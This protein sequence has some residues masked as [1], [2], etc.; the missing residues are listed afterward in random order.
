MK[1]IKVYGLF[2]LLM[3]MMPSQVFA[4]ALWKPGSVTPPRD[5]TDGLLKFGPCG[6]AS[7]QNLLPRSR[8]PKIFKP[9]EQVTV[10]WIETINHGGLFVIDY[11]DDVYAPL[12]NSV[13]VNIPDS[14]LDKIVSGNPLVRSKLITIPTTECPTCSIRIVQ[15]MWIKEFITPPL[16]PEKNPDGSRNYTKYF[17]CADI[18]IEATNNTPPGE[19][20]LPAA[21]SRTNNIDNVVLKWV[22]PSELVNTVTKLNNVAYRVLILMG[23]P[24]K[25]VTDAPQDGMQYTVAPAGMPPNKIGTATIVYDGNLETATILG[26]TNTNNLHFKFYTYN[27]SNLYSSTGVESSPVVVGPVAPIVTLSLTQGTLVDPVE[28]DQTKGVITATANVSNPVQGD[29]FTYKWSNTSNTSTVLVDETADKTDGI[30]SFDPVNFDAGSYDIKVIATNTISGLVSTEKT[31][32]AKIIIPQ[33]GGGGTAVTGNN[34]DSTSGGC[35]ITKSAKFDPLLLLLAL[36]S[37]GFITFRMI[38]KQ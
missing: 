35:S 28:F 8:T 12:L 36:L 18:R 15:Q 30:Y 3:A 2:L 6:G 22:N 33:Q 23:E 29:A 25:P 31:L 14:F 20:T 26:L 19:I 4:H 11:L 34:N 32:T 7:M 1:T 9:G 17:S 24:T 21:T 38:R 37:L 16:P 5:A 13:E 27:V 10:E